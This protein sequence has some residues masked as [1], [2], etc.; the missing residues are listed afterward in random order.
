YIKDFHTR[1]INTEVLG[2]AFEPEQYF[3]NPDGTPIRFDTDYFGNYR[4]VQII[5]GPFASP[6]DKIRVL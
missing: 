6:V 5:P 3:E 1:M 2:K 4:G